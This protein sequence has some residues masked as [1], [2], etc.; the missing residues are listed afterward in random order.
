MACIMCSGK[1]WRQLGYA[2]RSRAEVPECRIPGVSLGSWA[3][4][5]FNERGR[6]LVL[7]V[8]TRTC[9]TLL[10]PLGPAAQFLAD[11]AHALANALEDAGVPPAIKRTECAAVE[12]EPL[13]CLRNR[14]LTSTLNDVEFFC[15][16]EFAYHDDLRTV[17]RNLNHIPHPNRDPCVPMEA[18]KDL[19]HRAAPGRPCMAH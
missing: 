16:I 4:K 3:A 7:A 13:V 18:I 8:D 11:F 9:L 14:E 10:F 6:D 12:F 5:V 15:G 19:F 2:G 1:L 17:Q